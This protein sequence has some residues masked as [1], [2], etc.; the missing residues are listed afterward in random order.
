MPPSPYMI[1]PEAA[2]YTRYAEKSL[3]NARARKELPA[4]GRGGKLLFR[5]EDLDAWLAGRTGRR[6]RR[7]RAVTAPQPAT[8]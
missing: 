3:L 8:V 6:G 5:R 7:P 1:L 2:A 4:L